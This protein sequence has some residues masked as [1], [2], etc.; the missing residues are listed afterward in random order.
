MCSGI[1]DVERNTIA[2]WKG[3]SSSVVA[4]KNRKALAVL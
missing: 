2:T 3:Q 4:G 1:L